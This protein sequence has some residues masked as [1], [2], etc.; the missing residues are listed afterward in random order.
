MTPEDFGFRSRVSRF[1]SGSSS[2]S[3]F[4]FSATPR[5]TRLSNIIPRRAVPQQVLETLQRKTTSD[6]D[7]SIET[8]QRGINSLGKILVD[9]PS[10]DEPTI[11][12][13]LL[14]TLYDLQD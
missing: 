10:P 12:T 11:P 9:L 8:N 4:G 1:I 2:R 13:R 6:L 7:D 3:R 5:F 14:I